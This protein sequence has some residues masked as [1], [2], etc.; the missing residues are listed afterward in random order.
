MFGIHEVP[1][2]FIAA[3]ID[4]V[5]SDLDVGAVKIGMLGSAAAIDA[6]AAGLD[7]H[8]QRNVVLDP[9]MA[10]TFGRKTFA[11]G[12]DRRAAGLIPARASLTPNLPEAATLLDAP[13]APDES[14]MRAQ[15]Q[16]LLALGV[17]AVLIK[18]GHGSGPE[19]VD[20]LVDADGCE[21]FASPRVATKNTHGTGCTLRLPSPPD[22]PRDLALAEA[23]RD[24]QGLCERRDRRR[25]PAQGRH[26]PRPGASLSAV[27]VEKRLP[28]VAKY[29]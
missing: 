28:D 13:L 25:R 19:S 5:F 10:A 8:H 15:A 7:R 3:Q 23:V 26:R 12:C 1:A 9:V 4:A 11:C 27:V 21:R 18:G 14:E 22:S 24:G 20:I 16:K 17:G 6:V 2:A 29:R